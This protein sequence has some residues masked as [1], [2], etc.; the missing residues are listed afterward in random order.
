MTG[1][2][3][4]VD[5]GLG[6][7]RWNV[8]MTAALAASH[9]PGA[10]TLRFHR[11]PPSVLLGLHQALAREVRLDRCA[12]RGIAIARRASGGGAV[13]MDA[14]VLA[15]DVIAD[16]RR[17]G[18][19]LDRAGDLLCAGIA[20]ALGRFGLDATAAA[21]AVIAGGRKVCGTSGLADGPVVV[22]Q[23]SLLIACDLAAMADVLTV[24]SNPQALAARV[25]TIA[26][27]LLG[28]APEHGALVERLGA[29]IGDRL[30]MAIAP[31][32]LDQRE[33]DLAARFHAERFGSDAFVE[34]REAA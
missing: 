28:R 9:R 31:G 17:F 32:S 26:T 10:I 1:T 6:P 25:A 13:Y 15:F 12:R 21:G 29:A 2:L 8:A 3:R 23:A 5:T 33:R 19:C 24:A 22:F 18:G 34:G 16:R 14:G 7:A 30:G 11:Y 20:D 27:L 4:L